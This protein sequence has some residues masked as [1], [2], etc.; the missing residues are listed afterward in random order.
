MQGEEGVEGEGEGQEE[1]K[2]KG[3]VRRE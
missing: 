1:K 2:R 3:Q